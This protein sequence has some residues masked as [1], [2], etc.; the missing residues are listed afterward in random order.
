[1]ESPLKTYKSLLNINNIK[2]IAYDTLFTKYIV[3]N[4][5]GDKKLWEIESTDQETLVT[6]LNGGF[7][8]PGLMYTFIYR[9]GEPNIVKSGK[10]TKTYIDKVPIVFCVN[11]EKGKFSGINMNTLPHLERVKFLEMFFTEYKAFFKDVEDLTQNNKIA[12]NKTYIAAA[13]SNQGQ[14]IIK[15]FNAKTGSNFNYGYRT[16]D[17]KKVSRLRMIEFSEWDYIPFYD[18]KE[19]FKLMNQQQIHSLYWKSK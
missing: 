19:A 1:M 17:M 13:K 18:P 2:D 16:Y 11:T 4:L 3:E 9:A 10:S 5:K 14:K 15:L 12:L 6:Q 8:I 7:P